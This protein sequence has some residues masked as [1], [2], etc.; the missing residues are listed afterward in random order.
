MKMLKKLA[1]VSAISMI[2]AGAFAMEAMDDESMAA[3]TGQDGIT[4]KVIPGEFRDAGNS[5][6]NLTAANAAIAAGYNRGVALQQL[7]Y[8][9]GFKGLSIGEIRIHDDDGMG[10]KAAGVVTADSLNNSGA[11]VIGGGA[12]GASAYD[13]KLDSTFVFTHD[14]SSIQI[15]IDSV[16]SVAVATAAAATAAA[17]AATAATGVVT[18]AGGDV[19]TATNTLA[20]DRNAAANALVVGLTYATATTAQK[21]TIDADP[22]VVASVAALQAANIVLADA[23]EDE[24]NKLALS[25]NATANAASNQGAMLN[26]KISTPSLRIQTGAIYVANSNAA[27]M[28]I[29][30]D[31]VAAATTD[32]TDGTQV[33]GKVKIL[34]GMG[35]TMGSAT[36]N[37]QLG[38]EAQGAMIKLNTAITGG[39]TIDTIGLN[40]NGG[41]AA[42]ALGQPVTAGGQIYIGQM[43]IKDT[44]GSDLTVKVNVDVGSVN[45]TN[46]TDGNVVAIANDKFTV[47]GAAI[48]GITDRATLIAFDTNLAADKNK[49]ATVANGGATTHAA[50]LSAAYGADG[51]AGGVGVN[52]D[53]TAADIAKLNKA[54]EILTGIATLAGS[55]SV[56]QQGYNGLVIGLQQVGGVNG[57]DIAMNDL[58]L[59]DSTAGTMGDIQILGLNI[60]GTNVVITGH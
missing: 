38:N 42:P 53:G 18:T 46:F 60:N 33:T 6:A 40:D 39:M 59:G 56:I 15:D 44:G 32:D 43:K 14:A 20:A 29:D 13:K 9:S 22:T 45:T 52:A 19:T 30:A 25:A 57:M 35:L 4:I 28:G 27:E 3:A 31:G 23:Q 26:V 51:V 11:I 37:V 50:L 8:A 48:L 2:S 7:G 58:R 1:L 16:G 47:G 55:E 54:N 10:V 41:N 36:I 12:D 21:A 34:D 49:A 5:G 17:T 24:A